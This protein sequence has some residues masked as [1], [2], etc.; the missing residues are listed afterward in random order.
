MFHNKIVDKVIKTGA[1]EDLKLSYPQFAE[2]VRCTMLDIYFLIGLNTKVIGWE[3]D[4]PEDIILNLV[5]IKEELKYKYQ[6]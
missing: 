4:T 3:S 5:S 6:T 1:H 2:A